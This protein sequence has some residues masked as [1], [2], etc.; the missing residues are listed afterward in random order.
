ME[1]CAINEY[2]PDQVSPSGETLSELLKER[3]MSYSDLA[4]RMGYSDTDLVNR[5]IEGQARI[6]NEIALQ[7][8]QILGTPVGFWLNRELHY[9]QVQKGTGK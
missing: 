5:L 2:T 8:D 3:G 9:R 7:L 1:H 6:T 4:L